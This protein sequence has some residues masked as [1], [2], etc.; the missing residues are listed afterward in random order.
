MASMK[1][2]ARRSEGRRIGM[3]VAAAV[4]LAAL[5][6]LPAVADIRPSRVVVKAAPPADPP[7]EPIRVIRGTAPGG[8]ILLAGGAQPQLRTPRID[9]RIAT[10]DVFCAVDMMSGTS[11]DQA[12]L[13]YVDGRLV[14]RTSTY[15][16]GSSV[17]QYSMRSLPCGQARF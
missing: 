6:A 8:G 4:A 2:M 11:A 13:L 9:G 7:I 1:Q 10:L 17:S 3:V 14:A 12:F 15:R 5:S 16:P